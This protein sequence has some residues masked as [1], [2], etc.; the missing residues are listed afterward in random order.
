MAADT[1]QQEADGSTRMEEIEATLRENSARMAELREFQAET[2]R[3]MRET[4]RRMKETDRQ[5]KETDRRLRKA[6]DLFNS[7]WSRLLESLVE[8]DLVPLLQARG[9][10]VEE[11]GER[12][13]RKRNGENFEVDIVA[14]SSTEAVVVE[15]KTTLR[16]NDVVHFIDKL[17][18]FSSWSHTHRGRK[19]YGAMAYL[20]YD[21]E[22]ATYAERQGL[23]V[24]RATG[25]SA[26]IVNAPDFKPRAFD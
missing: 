12:F 9:I 16:P 21:S 4:D 6:E 3:E 23:F 14:L 13:K 10:E 11:I 5:M 2:A 17:S 20:R 26:S 7:Q 15:V 25:S 8:G 18:T 22:A 19:V 24:I 1:R